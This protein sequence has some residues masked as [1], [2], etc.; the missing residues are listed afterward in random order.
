M[1][2]VPHSPIDTFVVIK[3]ACLSRAM[4]DSGGSCTF[5]GHVESIRIE[6]LG[7]EV[8]TE[9]APFAGA[10]R[11]VVDG[12]RVGYAG[13][14][15]LTV[16]RP[17]Y[18]VPIGMNPRD[19]P[20]D[21]TYRSGSP[22]IVDLVSG[23]SNGAVTGRV[24]DHTECASSK[25]DIVWA[26]ASKRVSLYPADGRAV[27]L[28]GPFPLVPDPLAPVKPFVRENVV[29]GATGEVTC[30]G[31]QN[32]EKLAHVRRVFRAGDRR[33]LS[34]GPL[35]LEDGRIG[36]EVLN[37]PPA[38]W[39]SGG[40]VTAVEIS[41]APLLA[42]TALVVVRS[43][44]RRRTRLSAVDPGPGAAQADALI[45][46][47]VKDEYQAVLSVDTHA[48]PGSSWEKR[49]GSTRL[50]V[51]FRNFATARGPLRIAVTQA[52]DMGGVNATAAASLL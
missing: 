21:I 6:G 47:A 40:P 39:L 52:L 19:A 11:V 1:A 26:G 23:G 28:A 34:V 24:P 41:A 42:A 9:S 44:R 7:P 48:L 37:E 27:A 16:E 18:L 51:A 45:V 49:R 43:R 14:P 29:E 17:D 38:D 30:E 2:R 5:R 36:V 25:C 20:Y 8:L 35:Q 31:S 15:S 12:A 3:L 32:V 33:M 50:E 10:A 22:M 46:T 4:S 13:L